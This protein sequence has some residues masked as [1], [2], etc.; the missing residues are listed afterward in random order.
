MKVKLTKLILVPTLICF[1]IS[2]LL[3]MKFLSS[4]PIYLTPI[5]F[6]IILGSFNYK[7]YRHKIYFNQI[8]QVV[9][10]STIISFLCLFFVM[11]SYLL[12]VEI[13]D[14]LIESLSIT[15]GKESISKLAIFFSIYLVA[16]LSIILTFKGI[17]IYPKGKTTKILILA[18]L[19]VFILFGY[20][21]Y[22]GIRVYELSLLWMPL[23][24]FSIQLIIYQKE[25]F[26]V[27]KKLD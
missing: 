25:I 27:D 6:G 21:F 24:V 1:I 26:K 18:S 13:I 12:I 15:F 20:L 19:V 14:I 8:I 17:F 10:I 5:F 16:P 11:T 9:F 23:I 2:Y 22:K 4:T 3:D 7:Y